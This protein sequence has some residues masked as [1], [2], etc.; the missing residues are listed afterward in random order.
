M[1]LDRARIRKPAQKLLKLLKKIDREPT[2][3]NVHALRTN[4]RRVQAISGA[5]DL[6]N[7]SVLKEL[8]RL[9]R[10][11]GKVRDMDV[12]TGFAS[13]IHLKQDDNCAVQLLEYLGARR[14]KQAKKLRAEVRRRGSGLR[15]ELQHTPS[16]RKSAAADATGAAAKLASELTVPRRLDR[17]TLHP[18]RLKV[19]ELQYVLHMAAGATEAKFVKDLGRVK[20]AIGAWHDWQELSVI[21]QEV[22]DHG[23]PCA[24][25]Q[26]LD[27]IVKR[28]Y[29]DAMTL[30]QNFRKRY[31]RVNK[32]GE[33][34]WDA[35]ALLAA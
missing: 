29:T 26:E 8:E 4:T 23:T 20:D 12:L 7:T 31:L 22:L 17:A 1:A 30:V 3:D 24:L 25:R 16:L 18:Y 10:R 19:K 5:L 32:P 35:I 6:K 13:T 34:V 27:R 33:P 9:R 14:S 21:A 2:P 15:K 11:A 28:K